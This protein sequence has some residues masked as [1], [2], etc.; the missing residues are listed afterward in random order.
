MSNERRTLDRRRRVLYSTHQTDS[1]TGGDLARMR[2]ARQPSAAYGSRVHRRLRARWFSLVPVKRSSMALV[3]SIIFA[4]SSLLCLGHYASV[5]WPSIADTP[6]IS[7][8]LRLDRPDSFGRW[9]MVMML[10][11]TAGLSFLIY[12]LRRHRND[13]FAG[14][15]R[16]WRTVL[17]VALLSSL[18]AL[19]PIVDWS[20]ALLDLAFGRRVALAGGD[21]VRLIVLFGGV[22][23]LLQMLSEIH[24]CRFAMLTLSLGVV[25]WGI[26]VAVQW[27]VMEV[28]TISRWVL[29]TAMPLMASSA[30]FIATVAYL[31]MLYREVRQVEDSVSMRERW[32]RMRQDLFDKAPR[33]EIEKAVKTKSENSVRQSKSESV[34]PARSSNQSP[35]VQKQSSKHDLEDE[36]TEVETDTAEVQSKKRSWFRRREKSEAGHSSKKSESL[37]SESVDSSAKPKKKGRFSLRLK[38]VSHQGDSAKTRS[39]EEKEKSGEQKL[40]GGWLSRKEVKKETDVAK[41]ESSSL[42]KGRRWRPNQ[43]ADSDEA[44]SA[45]QAEKPKSGGLLNRRKTAEDNVVEKDLEK[46]VAVEAKQ[47]EKSSAK[48]GRNAEVIGS[49]EINWSSL[50]KSERRRLRKKLKRQNRAA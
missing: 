49:E 43:Q 7:G 28:T 22:I 39:V 42:K 36:S 5:S 26:T 8:P 24:R 30:V 34:K 25:C 40:L 47:T 41:K 19:V 38:P 1:A 27:N 10:A 14:R 33:E 6:G 37:K 2:A 35:S 29:V 20:G 48:S 4:I 50:S 9:F 15:Y 16:L 45:T 32:Q 31:R 17:I 18:Q 44:D 23:L 13:D 3:A 11:G 12:Q 21:W 46:E